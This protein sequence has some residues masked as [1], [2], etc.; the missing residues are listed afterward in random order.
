LHDDGVRPRFV[1]FAALAAA[2][3]AGAP[4]AADPSN[5]HEADVVF[6]DSPSAQSRA[7]KEATH[8]RFSH[9]GLVHFEKGQAFVVEAVGPVKR[10]PLAAW[11]A[12]GQGGHFTVMRL[13]E[14]TD[15]LPADALPKF[16]AAEARFA[17][18]PY[19][20]SFEWSDD[21]LYCSELVWKVYKEALG[22]ELGSLQR[23][24][25][26]DLTSA[27]VRAKLRERYGAH[28]PLDQPVISPGAIAASPLLETVV[29][30]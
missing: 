3:L 21:R 29:E 18:R 25:D 4:A 7:I 20:F 24:G 6:Q 16:A 8:S 17:G 12:R 10:T 5:L 15:G 1:I 2:G 11:I 30:R 9:V 19:D 13:K 26:L 27:V 14:A 23:L 28:V 22:V